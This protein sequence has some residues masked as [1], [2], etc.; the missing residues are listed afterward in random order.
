MKNICFQMTRKALLALTLVL[1]M[2]FPAL[3]QRITVTGTVYEPEGEPAI[4]A[5]VEVKGVPGVGAATDIDGNFSINVES[6]AILVVSYVGCDSQDI[7]VQGRTHIEV[8]LT[9]NTI[10]MNELVVVGYG[11]VKKSDATGSVGVV[12]PSEIE[13]GLATTAQDLLVGASPGVVVSTEGGNP[14]GGASIQIR[15]G[16]SLNASNAPLMVI[17]GVPMDGNNVKGSSNPLSLVS[18]ENVETMTILKGPSA[19]AIYGSRATNGVI[20][21]TTKRGKSGRPQVNFTAN[22]YVA[23]PR[24]YLDMM[25]SSEFAAFV[26]NRYGDDSMQAAQLGLNGTIYDTNWQKEVLRTTFSHDYSVSVGGTAGFL[27]YRVA[28]NY[29]G[30]DG[31]VRNTDNKRLGASV[32]LTPSFFDDLLNVSANVKGS[33]ITNN[34][35]GGGALGAAVGFNPTLPV[36]VPGLTTFNGYTTYLNGGI[37]AQPG[38]DG[39]Q[40]LGKEINNLYSK[41]PVSLFTDN[42]S[43][44]KVYQS[45]GNLQLDLKMPFLRELRANLNLGYDYSHGENA[46]YA[47]PNSPAAWDG[48]FA[49]YGDDGSSTVYIQQ[50][51]GN[52]NKELQERMTLMLEFYLN[53]NKTFESINS[54]VDAT[55]GYSWQRFTDKGHNFSTVVNDIADS[56]VIITDPNIN[57]GNPFNIADYAG[58][59]FSPTYYYSNR[60]QLLSFFGRVN[61]TFMDRYLL[62]ATMR[63]DGTSRFGKDNRWGSFPSFALGWKLLDESF[64]EGARGLMSELKLRAEWG[65]TGQQDLGSSFADIYPYLPIYSVLTGTSNSFLINNNYVQLAY[66]EKYN[67]SLKWEETRT[68]N[69]GLDF[70]FLN[71]R[72]NGSVE[73][74]VRKTKDLLVYADYPA[75]SN[76]SN[77]GFINLGDLKNTGIEFNI[78][79]RPVVAKDFVWNS[80]FNIA[81][82]KNKI[83]RLAEGASGETGS[84]GTAGNVQK[85]EVGHSAYSFYVYEQAFDADG[86]PLEGVYVDQNADGVI[87]NDDKIFYHHVHPDITVSWHNTV[88]WKNWDFGIVLRGAFGNWAYNKNQVDNSFVSATASAPL[89]NVMNNTYLFESTK[90]EQLQLSSYWVQNASFVRCDNITLGYTFENLLRNNLRLRLYGAVQNPFVITHYK[91]L[92]PELTYQQGIDSSVY[93][94]PITFTLGVVA[95]F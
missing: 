19:T 15:G 32:N 25:N 43:H 82:N 67:A 39:S 71:N 27:P 44:S 78:N 7:S 55:A 23:T 76:L 85:H 40:P 21:I 28:V 8:H 62:T 37:V 4:G 89:S 35:S 81:W 12:K 74:Y 68:W 38:A 69:V 92:D 52:R 9:T 59:Q 31:I 49:V 16:A 48:N 5:S 54:N 94:R 41:N 77:T 51:Y 18:P 34:Y 33:Y 58:Y 75:G 70:G 84:I 53:Y 46:S 80:N 36:K 24:N 88:N 64:M 6:D 42:Y 91:G 93:P 60:Y 50:G 57:S 66:P 61:Y 30:T 79:T 3:A 29:T 1:T 14:A 83:T 63:R 11:T 86:N 45:V 20:I 72:I 65:V 2:A 17:D 47:I 10:A 56:D 26:R 22:F 87:N 73:F 90:N 95:N 13:A